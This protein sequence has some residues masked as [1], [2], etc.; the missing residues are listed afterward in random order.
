MKFFPFLV[1]VTALLGVPVQ[2]SAAQDANDNSYFK[3]APDS[4]LLTDQAPTASITLTNPL[5][6]PREVWLAPEC[7]LGD[8][9]L[10]NAG[11][12]SGNYRAHPALDPFTAPWHSTSQCAVAWVSGYPRHLTLA[13]HERRSIPVRIDPPKSLEDGRY[14][15]RLIWAIRPPGFVMHY[16]VQ[17]TYVHGPHAPRD[18]YPT[19]AMGPG[20][21]AIEATP[22]AVTLDDSA[23]T[24][25]FT[26][27]NRAATPRDVWLSLD[28][29]WF[30]VNIVSYPHFS[31]YEAAWHA[32][33]PNAS[34]WLD[35][36]PQHLVLAPHERQ[37]LRI[38]FSGASFGLSD[39]G[40][41]YARLVYVE[42]PVLLGDTAYTTPSGTIN[43][44]VRQHVRM[45]A[46]MNQRVWPT[47][48]L[49]PPYL[50]DEYY[51]SDTT[52]VCDTVQQPGLGF[53]ATLHME[54]LD[55]TGR[56]VT[57]SGTGASVS[58][59]T[60]W[61]IDTTIARW[62]VTQDQIL[63]ESPFKPMPPAPVCFMLPRLRSGHYQVVFSGYQLQ[64]V[65]RQHPVRATLSINL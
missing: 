15:M 50:M 8:Y 47:L 63:G 64:D 35:G 37:T 17:V 58:P 5:A 61:G 22:A 12:K 28:C 4:I 33:T 45:R 54:V 18:W 57:R 41:K 38:H 27:I 36:F 42:S 32:F 16:E 62:E 26:L 31:Q 52:I 46:A 10:V 13:P 43:V 48:R 59:A 25:T 20:S 34:L 2:R 3:I 49:S 60:P 14:R 65:E 11:M 44:V 40:D 56:P 21:G 7:P 23:S 55:A 9:A 19:P 53:V 39:L 30:L 6:T 24:A 1:C 29:P 51:G